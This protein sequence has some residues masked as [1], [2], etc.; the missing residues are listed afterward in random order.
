MAGL[1]A[2]LKTYAALQEPSFSPVPDLSGGS[3]KAGVSGRKPLRRAWPGPLVQS[4]PRSPWPRLWPASIWE[5]PGRTVPGH[6][7]TVLPDKGCAVC[8]GGGEYPSP[9]CLH[10][11]MVMGLPGE[12]S[13]PLPPSPLPKS[14]A[15]PQKSSFS[16]TEKGRFQRKIRNLILV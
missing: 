9:D 6:D 10:L 16:P 2:V 1:C 8:V 15:D 12:N 3:V 4:P 7:N 14:L 11:T 13:T 5:G